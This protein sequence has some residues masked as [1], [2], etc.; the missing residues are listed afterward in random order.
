MIKVIR[1]LKVI[2][3]RSLTN[4]DQG[5]GGDVVGGDDHQNST[6]QTAKYCYQQTVVGGVREVFWIIC[7]HSRKLHKKRNDKTKGDK[8]L[9]KEIFTRIENDDIKDTRDGE[10]DIYGDEDEAGDI[11]WCCIIFTG[12]GDYDCEDYGDTS[13]E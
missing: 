2:F 13:Q 10:G 8:V 6:Y 12:W 1:I 7:K 9:W 4:N 5:E 11:T 3:T